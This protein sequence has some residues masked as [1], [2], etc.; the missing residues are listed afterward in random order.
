MMKEIAAIKDAVNPTDFVCCRFYDGQD[1]VNTAK[2]F[3]DRL[4]F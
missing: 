3:N 4:N 1:A 2:E